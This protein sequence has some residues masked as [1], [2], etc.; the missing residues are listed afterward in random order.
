MDSPLAH[1]F[2]DKKHKIK[3]LTITLDQDLQ[4]IHKDLLA[5]VLDGFRLLPPALSSF[6]AERE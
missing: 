5:L 4:G 3:I 2:M 6:E 1:D